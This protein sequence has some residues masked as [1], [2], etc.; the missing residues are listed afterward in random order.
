MPESGGPQAQFLHAVIDA[1]IF[2]VF[3]YVDGI[4]D[5][6]ELKVRILNL[7]LLYLQN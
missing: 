4:I 1:I 3:L 7:L 5:E 2:Q 6:F